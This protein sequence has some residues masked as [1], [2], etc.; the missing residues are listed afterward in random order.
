MHLDMAMV[1]KRTGMTEHELILGVLRGTFPLPTRGHGGTCVWPEDEVDDWVLE[2]CRR[3]RYEDH[4]L[5]GG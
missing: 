2:A 5:A 1:R 3:A 4:P